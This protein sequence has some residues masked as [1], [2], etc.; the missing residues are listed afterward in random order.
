MIRHSLKR[1]RLQIRRTLLTVELTDSATAGLQN[2]L[3]TDS[4]SRTLLILRCATT[5]SLHSATDLLDTAT[6]LVSQ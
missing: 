6:I 4:N 1:L 3:G 2:G 5:T